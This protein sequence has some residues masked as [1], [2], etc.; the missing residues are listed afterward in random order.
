MEKKT[1]LLPAADN[2]DNISLLEPFSSQT[3]PESTQPTKPERAKKGCI[4]QTE[5]E[6]L[7][8]FIKETNEFFTSVANREELENIICSV[9][10]LTKNLENFRIIRIVLPK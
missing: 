5:C 3:T 6:I 9:K 4:S 1:A 10:V 7:I 8:K 2:Y